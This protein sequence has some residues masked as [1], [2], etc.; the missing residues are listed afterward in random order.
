MSISIFAFPSIYL[1]RGAFFSSKKKYYNHQRL[2][3]ERFS[4][5]SDK[6]KHSQDP[7][8]D[9]ETVGSRTCVENLKA[10]TF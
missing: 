3:V 8:R 6:R 9:L 2:S 5:G 4:E 7:L 10:V 1:H